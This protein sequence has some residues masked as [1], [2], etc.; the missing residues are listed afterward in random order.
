MAMSRRS[1]PK[2]RPALLDIAARILAD[3]GPRALSTRRLATEAGSSTM[4]VYTYF[5]GMRGLIRELV[6]EGFARL[7]RYFTRISPTDDP[8]ADIALFG[9]AYRHNAITNSHMYG[10][11]FGG[12]SLAGFSLTERDRQ[13]GRYTMAGV[14]ECAQRCMA[15]GR[16][17]PGDPVLVA[18]QMWLAIHGL[19]TLELGAYLI[20]PCNAAVCLEAQLKGLMVGA[21]D[22]PEAARR[23][24]ELSRTRLEADVLAAGEPPPGRLQVSR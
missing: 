7:E 11:M 5:G 4:A 24:V 8:V 6:H 16:F 18:H 1:D 14:V 20:D 15:V 12:Q 13:Y 3:E 2:A 22:A 19:V 10:V 9:R 21:G 17:W 23:S